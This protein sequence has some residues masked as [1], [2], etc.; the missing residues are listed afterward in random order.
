MIE[1]SKERLSRRRNLG[2]DH[3]SEVVIMMVGVLVAPFAYP[4]FKAMDLLAKTKAPMED[5]T[6]KNAVRTV[7]FTNTC[8]RLIR[9]K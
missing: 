8:S 9:I 6:P 5:Q 3:T 1:L 7:R 2:N 4:V